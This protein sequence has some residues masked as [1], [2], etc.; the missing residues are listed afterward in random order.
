MR[1]GIEYTSA[2]NQRA[3]I[4]RLTRELVAA[5]L[6]LDEE[7]SYLL[8]K[9]RDSRYMDAEEGIERDED[10]PQNARLFTL[11]FTERMA[12]ILWQRLR[13][14]LP[15]DWLTGRLDV[16]HS[17]DFV[18][19]PLRRARSVVTIH[20]LSF[21]I[22]PQFF[23]PNALQYL[24]SAVPRTLNRADLV[25]TDSEATKV[26]LISCFS[27]P[28]E[29]IEV[30]HAGVSPEFRRVDDKAALRRVSAEYDLSSPFI[31]TMG[32]IQPRK[33]LRRLFQAYDF[34]VQDQGIP[35]RLVVA[36]EKGWLYQDIYSEVERLGLQ[37]RV[38][39]LGFVP[40]A[41]LPTLL[42]MA[43]LFVY[44]SLYEGFG[45]P[46]VEAM[47]CGTVTV[48]SNT[49]SLPE[50]AAD[51]ALQVEPTDVTALAEAMH[52]AI[53]EE[54]LRKELVERGLKQVARFTW[55]EAAR[56]M[57]GVYERLGG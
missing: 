36:G 14:P 6:K 41:D 29:M 50:V 28:A 45:L 23:E 10:A 25:V 12:S 20:D 31:L 26:D 54:G 46:V 38:R 37:E 52:R 30:V 18:L 33:N 1:I 48:I 17:P 55:E 42:S 13:V 43:D 24:N 22:Y 40:D 57:L 4:G 27:L 19:P 15:L 39:F 21:I 56:K 34:L 3:G 44:P 35:H 5:L 9:G 8:I 51:A 11:P 2:V 32:T 16:F 49:S 47:A 7:N 53:S